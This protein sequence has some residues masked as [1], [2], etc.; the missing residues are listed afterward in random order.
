MRDRSEQKRQVDE[1]GPGATAATAAA[2]RHPPEAA[3]VFII[4]LGIVAAAALVRW[5]DAHR[6]PARERFE[7]DEPYVTPEVAKRLSMGFN[8]LIADWY[9]MRS[10]QY[11]GRK[12]IAHRDEIQIDDLSPLGIKYLAP[13]LEQATTLDPQ[14]MAAYEYSAVVLP[15][16]NREA[17]VKLTEKGISANPG[18]W[19][20][21]HHLG[22]IHWQGG[23][24]REASEA[25]HRGAE[26]PG[27]PP[28]MRAMAAQMEAS[29]GSRDVARN[30]YRR[31]YTESDD[32]QIKL[33][34]LKRLLQV[35][36]LDQRDVIRRV[37][38]AHR[39]RNNGHCPSTWSEVASL[40]S[41]ARLKVDASGAP[42]DPSGVPYL[43]IHKKCEADLDP[44][45]EIPRR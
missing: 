36:S 35:D 43:L 32:K 13:L 21:Y 14:F 25:Y 34:A 26:V 33:M 9:W 11:V 5:M 42:L 29:G 10:L 40:L 27:A 6:P 18:A 17:A 16:I 19:Q 3:L 38:A 37:L 31:I 15:A 22:Y 1:H 44:L 28:W 39:E 2:F 23:R 7:I 41:G 24:F 12:M 20:L 30:I 45:S 4:L 8:G